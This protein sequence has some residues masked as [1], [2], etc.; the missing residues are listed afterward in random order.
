M[1]NLNSRNK[2][3][4]IEIDLEA[5]KSFGAVLLTKGDNGIETA[6]Y[7]IAGANPK[8][9]IQFLNFGGDYYGIEDLV[10]GRDS[11]YDGDFNDITFYMS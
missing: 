1:A 5:G 4:T 7:S 6:L 10:Q 2:S 3:G 8:Q 11:G 9:G